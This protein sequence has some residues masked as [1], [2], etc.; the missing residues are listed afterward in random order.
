MMLKC[1]QVLSQNELITQPLLNLH[2]NV[3]VGDQGIHTNAQVVLHVQ[4]LAF[5]LRT[6]LGPAGSGVS[7]KRA[8]R[9]H[10]SVEPL[11][12]GLRL[13]EGQELSACAR[14]IRFSFS[15]AA[16]PSEL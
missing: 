6:S 9:H 12:P 13:K 8:Q 11:N 1:F 15:C 5:P 7:W 3:P 2:K 14:G 10:P 4:L 16:A